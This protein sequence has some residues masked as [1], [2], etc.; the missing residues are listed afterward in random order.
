MVSGIKNVVENCNHY[1]LTMKSY[2]SLSLILITVLFYGCISTSV[3]DHY[4]YKNYNDEYKKTNR[5]SYSFALSPDEWNSGIESTEISFVREKGVDF[6]IV[7]VY[8]VIERSSSTFSR[9]TNAYAKAMF[10]IFPLE[11]NS[12]TSDFRQQKVT[13]Q[14][15]TSSTDTLS[16]NVK[17]VDKLWYEDKFISTLQPELVNAIK[18]TGELNFRFYYG[19]KVVTF[20]IKGDK[21]KKIKSILFE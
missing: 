20:T 12:N 4:Q 2:L 5:S 14:S 16:K 6:D 10:K 7:K 19:A 15:S 17:V 18:N 13:K 9:D 11:I 3:L 1:I 21:L 8:W